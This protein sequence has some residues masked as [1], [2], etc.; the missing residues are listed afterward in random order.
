MPKGN[1]I[2]HE[3]IIRNSQVSAQTPDL[4]LTLRL[5]ATDE[6]QTISVK[7]QNFIFQEKHVNGELGYVGF[8]DAEQIQSVRICGNKPAINVGHNHGI[9]GVC[10][11][12]LQIALSFATRFLWSSWLLDAVLCAFSERVQ[13]RPKTCRGLFQSDKKVRTEFGDFHNTALGQDFR[14]S[15]DGKD[16]VRLRSLQRYVLGGY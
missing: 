11:Q 1:K 2:C 5:L 14:P 9:D 8:R 4:A 10:Q 13:C 15:S 12:F 16:H 7:M 3:N 6:R